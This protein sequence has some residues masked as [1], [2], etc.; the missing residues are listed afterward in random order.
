M[1]G[2][3]V[4]FKVP[5]SV[6]GD[7]DTNEFTA[8]AYIWG[9]PESPNVRQ[10]TARNWRVTIWSSRFAYVPDTDTVLKNTHG[11][12]ADL[13]EKADKY[14]ELKNHPNKTV[15]RAFEHAELLALLAGE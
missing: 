5:G 9:D 12:I 6:V 11:T 8:L 2:R 4:D 13:F 7:N 15:K 14:T 10:G 1:K 3:W